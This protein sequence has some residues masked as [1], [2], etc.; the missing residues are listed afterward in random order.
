MGVG[1]VALG[2]PHEEMPGDEAQCSAFDFE[3]C[4]GGLRGFGDDGEPCFAQPWGCVSGDAGE[5][6]R[7]LQAAGL[8]AQQ[9]CRSL[10]EPAGEPCGGGYSFYEEHGV[11]GGFVRG[12][13]CAG[14]QRFAAGCGDHRLSAREGGEGALR[15]ALVAALWCDCGGAGA[16]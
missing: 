3:R 8:C 10:G 11:S 15:D 2:Q 16:L 1:A 5:G 7:G 9:D 12:D 4:F 13:I 6:A 14:G